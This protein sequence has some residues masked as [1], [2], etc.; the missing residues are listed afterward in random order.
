MDCESC[1]FGKYTDKNMVNFTCRDC[2]DG[3]YQSVTSSD[4]SGCKDCTQGKATVSSSLGKRN[5]C[6]PCEDGEMSRRGYM[7]EECPGDTYARART[8]GDTDC[9]EHS[10]P[11]AMDVAPRSLA[12]PSLRSDTVRPLNTVEWYFLGDLTTNQNILDDGSRKLLAA[13]PNEGVKSPFAESCANY[14]TCDVKSTTLTDEYQAMCSGCAESDGFVSAGEIDGTSGECNGNKYQQYFYKNDDTL[15]KCPVGVHCDYQYRSILGS[16]KVIDAE[17]LGPFVNAEK[18]NEP[19]CK[20][21]TV[22]EILDET[23][24]LHKTLKLR[25]LNV[26]KV[27]W[28]SILSKRRLEYVLLAPISLHAM[29]SRT[30]LIH[31]LSH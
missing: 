5:V 26:L 21:F 2:E 12:E 8:L 27:I 13:V 15:T 30:R 23:S 20:Q 16:E 24:H 19:T 25:A 31:A 17:E 9:Y 14:D 3:K 11:S 29:I 28:D 1:E 10:P 22:C 7:C 4:R 18:D 6:S